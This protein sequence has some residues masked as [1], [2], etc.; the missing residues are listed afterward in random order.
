MERVGVI[1]DGALVVNTILWNDGTK[2]QLEADG[3]TDCEE[4]TGLDPQP[5]IGWI[6]DRVYGYRPPKPY[7]SWSWDNNAW[8]PPYPQPSPEHTWDETNQ[9]WVAQPSIEP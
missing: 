6:W 1:R 8:K 4:T 7:A 5:R 2:A 9:A 3:I